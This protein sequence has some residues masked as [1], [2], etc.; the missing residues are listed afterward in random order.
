MADNLHKYQHQKIGRFKKAITIL[1]N[2]GLFSF[3]KKFKEFMI[4][5]TR[6]YLAPIIIYIKP[7]KTFSFRGKEI[8]YLFHKYNVTWSN[9]RSVEIPLVFDMLRQPATNNILEVGAVLEH[10]YPINLVCFR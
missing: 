8:P 5:R 3:F 4:Y 1:S 9:E 2:E 10:Y 6:T 7:K